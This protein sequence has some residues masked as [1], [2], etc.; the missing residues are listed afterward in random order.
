MISAGR[1]LIVEDDGST[2]LLLQAIVAR[3]HLEPIVAVDG[4]SAMALLGVSTFDAI[5]LDLRIPEVD[6]GTILRSLDGSTG[7]RVVI[8]TAAPQ[9]EWDR[10][11]DRVWGVL[12][13]PFDIADLE[14]QLLACL[15][16]RPEMRIAGDQSTVD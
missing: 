9:A 11:V 5:L 14:S 1:V 13:K 6:G 10:Y 16:A 2:R 7:K 8:V 15:A 3:N 12:Q 4:R